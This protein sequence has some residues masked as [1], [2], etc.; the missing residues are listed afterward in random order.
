MFYFYIGDVDPCHYVAG[1]FEN[2]KSVYNFYRFC[3]FPLDYR[4]ENDSGA[5]ISCKI[6]DYK[7]Y[8]KLLLNFRI[9]SSF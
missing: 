6:Q 7:K 5:V 9:S 8:K 1:H 3:F 4:I 2:F